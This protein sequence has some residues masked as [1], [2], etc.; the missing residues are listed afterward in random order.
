M[1]ELENESVYSK[2]IKCTI[3][4]DRHGCERWWIDLQCGHAVLSRHFAWTGR[5]ELCPTCTKKK[6]R[7]K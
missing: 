2:V 6:G 5:D 7:E 1:S 3:S 4:R